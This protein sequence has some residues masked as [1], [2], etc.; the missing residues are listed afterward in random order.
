MRGLGGYL[1]I[2]I[3]VLHVAFGV[4][5]GYPHLV[6]MGRAGFWNVIEGMGP[7]ALTFWFIYP[8]FFWVLLGQLC[9]WVERQLARPLPAWLGWELA[10]V[11]GGAAV[12]D[13][14][15]GHWLLV[16]TG[17]YMITAARKPR[18]AREAES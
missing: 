9:A 11:A 8:A 2:G 4:A 12:L 5:I 1:L 13:P 18:Q 14:D 17:I 10:I 6:E 3:G 16:G 15:S 7:R